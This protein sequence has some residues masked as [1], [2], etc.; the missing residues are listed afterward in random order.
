[1]IS[2]ERHIASSLINKLFR[3]NMSSLHVA[4]QFSVGYDSEVDSH[5]VV[6]Y[7]NEIAKS[8][9]LIVIQ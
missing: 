1:M 6:L 3:V 4:C 9:G 5:A 7:R 2:L 8:S